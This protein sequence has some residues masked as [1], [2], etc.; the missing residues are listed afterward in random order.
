MQ[1]IGHEIKLGWNELVFDLTR[2][3]F[4]CLPECSFINFSA[5]LVHS[6]MYY[7]PKS[8]LCT[9]HLKM[10]RLCSI[11]EN[12]YIW[13]VV[14]RIARFHKKAISCL[15]IDGKKWQNL[16]FVLAYISFLELHNLLFEMNQT[17][18]L[19]IFSLMKSSK[20]YFIFLPA[21]YLIMY[22]MK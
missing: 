3:F 9:I 10:K 2:L 17:K 22:L 8:F 12:Y 16:I 20:K 1:Y 11:Y 5:P 4:E 15:R 7:Q 21:F 14:L 6:I 19:S 18:V 13:Y